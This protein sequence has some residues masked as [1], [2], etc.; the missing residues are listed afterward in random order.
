[1]YQ[2]FGDFE[3]SVKEATKAIEINP[4][5][6]PGYVN[7]AGTYVFLDRLDDAEKTLQ[8]AAE[9]KLEN[10]FILIVRYGIDFLKGDQ[11]GMERDAA[12]GRGKPGV[13]SW[14]SDQEALVAAYFGHMQS[15]RKL[16]LQASDAAKQASQ[17]EPAALIFAAPALREGFFGYPAEARRNATAALALSK[18]RDVEYGAALALALAGDLS[19][20]QM[21]ASDLETRFPEDTEV[22][23]AYLPVLRA[24]LALQH[25]A[26]S[27]TIELLQPATRYELGAPASSISGFFGALYPSYV[28]G[29]AYLELNQ[30]TQAAVEFQRILDHRGIVNNDPIG[31]LAHYQLGKALAMS[32]DAAKAKAAYEDFL[33]QWKD[34][35]SDIPILTAAKKDYAAL[36]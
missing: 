12:Q 21:L 20:S 13:G 36:N 24:V 35:D 3:N 23:F 11:G 26:P 30:G 34:A 2:P 5:F 32:G 28:R 16:T 27:N 9:S 18:G 15:A 1:M 31:A 19:Q 7:L 4:D 29:E 6:F 8:K 25:H 17:R 22:K 14:M 33:T 10:P